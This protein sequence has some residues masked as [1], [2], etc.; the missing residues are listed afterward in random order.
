M[1]PM[2][3]F[4]YGLALAGDVLALALALLLLALSLSIL[5]GIYRRAKMPRE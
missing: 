1:T 2:H 4:E 3:F 5:R